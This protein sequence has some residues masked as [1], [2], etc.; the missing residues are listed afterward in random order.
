MTDTKTRVLVVGMGALGSIYAWLLQKSG[1]VEV[2]AVCRSN[3]KTVQDHGFKIKSQALGNH[4][5]RPTRVVASVAEAAD[6][7][8]DFILFCT[9]ALPNLGDNS[10]IIAPVVKQGTV[11]ILVQNGIGIEEPFAERYPQA[12]LVSVVAYI[13]TSQPEPGVIE[14][15]MLAALI[16]G[17]HGPG[18][19]PVSTG[20][21]AEA[22]GS[23]G[24]EREKAQ[25][26]MAT[27]CELWNANGAMCMM[28]DD[29][30][31]YRWLKLVWNASF[32]TVS[33]VSGGNDTR[34]MLD[35]EGCRDLVRNIMQ[36]VYTVGARVTGQELPVHMGMDGPDAFIADA[37][38]REVAV[39]P[40]ML[41]DFCARR[42]MEHDV[43]LGNPLRIA[44]R[45]GV[46]APHMETVYAML[47]MVE[48]G[49][50]GAHL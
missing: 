25:R 39:Q 2:T 10:E 45:L 18:D 21:A 15:G 12:Q 14:H 28:T 32:N 31:R 6:T 30:Q 48:K 40:S 50:L 47:V 19:Q 9:K 27:L 43:I 1:E 11:I 13:D 23:V 17:F 3:Y 34:Q 26:G 44:R 41:M 16:M 8:Y 24:S 33:V 38:N 5:Y 36:E 35:N 20:G 42:P 22:D 49:Y 37:D 46:P 4:T 7:D 29:I